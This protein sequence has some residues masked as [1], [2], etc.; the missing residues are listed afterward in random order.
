MIADKV[1]SIA[2]ESHGERAARGFA[3][4]SDDA[5]LA[6][7]HMHVLLY[8]MIEP[9]LERMLGCPLDTLDHVRINVCDAPDPEKVGLPAFIDIGPSH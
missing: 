9:L 8:R 6:N 4:T 2:G 5:K 3:L 7:W 1:A